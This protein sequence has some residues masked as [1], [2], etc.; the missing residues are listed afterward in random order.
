MKLTVKQLIIFILGLVSVLLYLRAPAIF[1]IHYVIYCTTI[2]TCSSILMLSSNCKYTLLKFEFI[3]LIAFF[4]TNYVYPL[5]FYSTNPYF[6]LF[7][8]PFNEKY[9]TRGTAL[10]TVAATWYNYGIFENKP[11]SYPTNI[12]HKTKNRLLIPNK[13]AIILF[14]LFIPSLYAIYKTNAYSTEFESSLVNVI[15]KYVVIYILF[16]FIYNNRHSTLKLLIQKAIHTPVIILTIIYTVLFLLIGSRTIPLNIA[17]FSLL[18]INIL[19]HKFTKQNVA[20]LIIG[21]AIL[22]AAI[23][24]ARGGSGTE[25]GAIS[26]IWDVGADLTINNRSLYVLIEEV[27]KHGFS[28]GATMIM[29]ILSIIPFAQSIFLLI[30]GLPLSSISSAVLVTD[31]H[32]GTGYNP[33]RFGLGTNLVGDV[34]YAYGLLGVIALFWIFGY[35]LKRLYH[36]IRKGETVALLIYAIFFM[37]SIY[38]TRSGYLTPARDIVWVLG[39]YWLSNHKFKRT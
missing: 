19:I 29:N 18:I 36:N 6:S 37:D 25:N 5:I 4:F 28:Y 17:L 34:Y 15:L 26:T 30:T 32:F 20:I 8:M 2:F 31:L 10:A 7:S 35:I 22:L 16:A 13:A 33:D 11:Q 3:F 9:I 38:Y 14:V 21:G 23:G 12:F 1:S 27:D 24:I 39:V